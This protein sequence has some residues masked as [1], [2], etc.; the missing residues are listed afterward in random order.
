MAPGKEKFVVWSQSKYKYKLYPQHCQGCFFHIP[1]SPLASIP[2]TYSKGRRGRF[3]WSFSPIRPSCD[4][5][6]DGITAAHV[7]KILLYA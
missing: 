2:I 1:Q 5:S 3:S 4:P 7:V 6:M